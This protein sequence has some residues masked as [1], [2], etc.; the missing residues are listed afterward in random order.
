MFSLFMILYT[1]LWLTIISSLASVAV[2]LTPPYDG[3]LKSY[4]IY[5][6]CQICVRNSVAGRLVVKG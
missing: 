3:N 2:T 1:F 6:I 4:F 5:L